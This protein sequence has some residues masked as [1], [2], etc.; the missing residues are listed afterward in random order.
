MLLFN[1]LRFRFKLFYNEIGKK[2]WNNI[3]RFMMLICIMSIVDVTIQL[4]FHFDAATL[5]YVCS[6]NRLL[7][8]LI[9][10]LLSLKLLPT[11]EW[12]FPTA[13]ELIYTLLILSYAIWIYGHSEPADFATRLL[14]H[15]HTLQFALVGVSVYEIS[16][17]G[18][19]FL[20]QKVSPTVLFAA[21]FF[22]FIIIG[23]GLLMLP[24]SNHGSLTAFDALF[25]A[26]SAVCV[27]GLSVI[28]TVS[29]LTT[30]GQVILMVLIQIGGIG[31]MTFTSFFATSLSH[32]ASIKNQM[33]IKD[34]VSADNMNDIFQTL[35]RIIFVTLTIELAASWLIFNELDANTD[36]DLSHRIFFAAFHAI[37]GFCNAGFSIA[38]NGMMNPIFADNH[39]IGIIV[40]LT[41]VL[42]G[43][44]FPLQSNLI[45]WVQYKIKKIYYHLAGKHE[46]LFFRSHLL[47][48]NSRLVF[49]T[50]L[51]LLLLGMGIFIVSER[52]HSQI[53]M[54]AGDRIFESFFLS[55]TARTAGFNTVDL[56]LLGPHTI[57]I[58][59]I[60]MWIGCAP[61][62]TGG[63]IKTSTFAVAMFN[64]FS[65]FRKTDRIE[66]YNRRVEQ[67]S[68]NKAFAIIMLSILLI[69]I[70]TM[71]T[72]SFDPQFGIMQLLFEN[73]SAI[74]T[75]GL[76]LDL[77]PHLSV[78]SKTVLIINMFIG[79][80]GVLSFV[81]CFVGP[82]RFKSY[83]FP[84]E[85][86]TL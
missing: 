79:R 45:S 14:A 82:K 9:A 22:F 6:Y 78:A 68:V 21:S 69:F 38:E 5:D 74:S 16:R 27:T 40:A 83:S 62:S 42:G 56:G 34:L 25:T 44:G 61:L 60:L 80:I 43:M 84:H 11:T 3:E 50:H 65:V 67:E 10:I 52:H 39:F 28:D 53:D 17:I 7:L 4:G 30:F 75:V 41:I 37:S 48:V 15:K 2:I 49:F 32:K 71:L 33:V 54:S 57:M 63:G 77:T 66:I 24:R 76:T 47:N 20:S 72:K 55:T 85:S 26:T 29:C 59:L 64:M 13:K 86:I 1:L 73:C 58:M 31:V 12:K 18:I 35:K 23:S 70:S 19:S 36:F 51:G 8:L 46:R 81:M